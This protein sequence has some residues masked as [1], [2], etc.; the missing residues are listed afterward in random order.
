MCRVSVSGGGAILCRD[1]SD[2][3]L[4]GGIDATAIPDAEFI[5]QQGSVAAEVQAGTA[6]DPQLVGAD[7]CGCVHI[8]KGFEIHRE[9]CSIHP[10]K[11]RDASFLAFD[12]HGPVF[13]SGHPHCLRII[14]YVLG[15]LDDSDLLKFVDRCCRIIL[16][17]NDIYHQE[18]GRKH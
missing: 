18:G 4:V 11:R 9:T 10:D 1:P 2:Q 8:R 7:G 12:G 14:L 3:F 5:F 17:N 6:T 13:F 15:F 16:P